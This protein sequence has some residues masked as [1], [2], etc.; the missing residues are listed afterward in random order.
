MVHTEQPG[1]NGTAGKSKTV[2]RWSP[3]TLLKNLWSNVHVGSVPAKALFLFTQVL[4][5]VM[6]GHATF[7]VSHMADP[8]SA[9]ASHY[10]MMGV[11]I[12]E[13]LLLGYYAWKKPEGN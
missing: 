3:V 10:M 9:P 2:S 13:I 12:M 8:W 5:I 7:V 4:L 1:L 11:G 6:A